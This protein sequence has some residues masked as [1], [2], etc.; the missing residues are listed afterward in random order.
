MTGTHNTLLISYGNSNG[1]S[2]AGARIFV[3]LRSVILNV[4]CV[5]YDVNE[6]FDVANFFLL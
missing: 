5:Y 4:A 3:V 6:F 2:A 1:L